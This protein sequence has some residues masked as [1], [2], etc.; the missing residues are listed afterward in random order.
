MGEEVVY[1]L[2]IKF[3]F[4]CF[5][6]VEYVAD[7]VLTYEEVALLQ[8]NPQRKR[9]VVLIGQWK[10]QVFSIPSLT[11]GKCS[12][13]LCLFSQLLIQSKPINH[14]WKRLCL[15][16]KSKTPTTTRAFSTTFVSSANQN[17]T[18]ARV[19]VFSQSKRTCS[20]SSL[21]FSKCLTPRLFRTVFASHIFPGLLNDQALFI[22]LYI[23]SLL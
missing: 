12:T 9:P 7:E 18:S 17:P 6:F 3:D 23:F 8:P 19:C 20:L 2:I 14:T 15:L 16:S 11:S 10:H 4:I 22:L 5:L 13:S 1:F 21:I